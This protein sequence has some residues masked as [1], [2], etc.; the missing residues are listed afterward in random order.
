MGPLVLDLKV[1]YDSCYKFKFRPGDWGLNQRVL[2]TTD[3][4]FNSDC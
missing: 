3:V 4:T 1:E 2:K